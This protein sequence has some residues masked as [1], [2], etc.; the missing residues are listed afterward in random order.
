MLIKNKYKK[1]ICKFCDQEVVSKHFSRHLERKHGDEVEVKK[2]LTKKPNSKERNQLLSLIRNEGSLDDGLRGKII[3][4]KCKAGKEVHQQDYALCK[5]CK[6]FYKRRY[7]SRHIKN[8]FAKPSGSKDGNRP[9]SESFIY[10]ASQ[11]KYGALLNSLQAK[12]QIFER[13]QA[14]EVTRTASSDILIVYYAEDLLKKIKMKRRF[15]RISNKI[16]ECAKFLI[17]MRKNKSYDD[18]VSV[19]KPEN[20]D[21]T[22]EAVKSLSRYDVSHRNFGAPSLALNFRTSL[23]NLCDLAIKIIQRRKMPHLIQD[24]EQTLIELDRFKNMVDMQW[25]IEI[26]SLALKDLNEKSAIKPKLLCITE[27]IIKLAKLTEDKA[28]QAYQ[29]LLKNKKDQVSYRILV[30]AVLVAT[31]LHNRTRVRDVQYLEWHSLKQQFE[32]DNTALQAELA[33]SLTEN[34]TILTENYKRIVSTGKGGRP[35]TILIPEKLF[36]YY[37]FLHKLRAEPWFPS[38]NSYFFTYPESKF[39]IDGCTVMQ[40]YARLSNAKYPQLL[41]SCKLRKHIATVTQLLNLQSDGIDQL[42]RFMGHQ[43]HETFY[44]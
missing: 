22:I 26:G 34:E 38:G 30:E 33:S 11:R 43:T 9:L 4:K 16:R 13:M 12:K 3:P 31:I 6:G 20:F 7:L 29:V 32:T 1:T 35:V 42:A 36:Q 15:Y 14:D 44:K 27:D 21:S 25:A 19:L 10:E 41:T 17:E 40:K 39:W 2:V 8:C 23:I 5:Y 24:I 37:K 28:E 18:L